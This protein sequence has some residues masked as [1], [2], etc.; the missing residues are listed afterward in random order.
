ML[1]I[2]LVKWRKYLTSLKFTYWGKKDSKYIMSRN[3]LH[4]VPS[5]VIPGVTTFL[6]RVAQSILSPLQTLLLTVAKSIFLFPV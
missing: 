6:A 3:G 4:V 5:C 1:D 2:A